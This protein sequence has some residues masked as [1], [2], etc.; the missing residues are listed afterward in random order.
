MLNEIPKQIEG[1]KTM[2]IAKSDTHFEVVCREDKDI[3][4]EFLSICQY[5][6]DEGFYLFG[7]DI[8]FN[9][10]TDFYYE[11]VNEALVDAIRL[12]QTDIINWIQVG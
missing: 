7:C 8:D 10:H 9:T 6:R 1:A 2:Y 3:L 5:D 4:I 11:D 12:Y